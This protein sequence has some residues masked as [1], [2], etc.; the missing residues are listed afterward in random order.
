[1]DHEL[2]ERETD[3]IVNLKEQKEML[4][5]ALVAAQQKK[6]LKVLVQN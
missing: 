5:E 1:M 3:V 4:E 6:E 2:S